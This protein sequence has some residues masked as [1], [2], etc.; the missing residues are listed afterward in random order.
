MPL[1]A[2]RTKACVPRASARPEAGDAQPGDDRRDV[3]AQLVQDD[4]YANDENQ[5]LDRAL[6]D[7]DNCVRALV[8]FLVR[9]RC[10]TQDGRPHNMRKD[11]AKEEVDRE[12]DDDD[13]EDCGRL[14]LDV[15]PLNREEGHAAS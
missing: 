5:D 1:I 6:N 9:S 3:H 10:A 4:D 8:H 11:S 15:L 14:V 13:E 7:E 2:S 12:N